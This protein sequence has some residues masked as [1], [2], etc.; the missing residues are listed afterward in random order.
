MTLITPSAYYNFVHNKPSPAKKFYTIGQRLMGTRPKY[1]CIYG[2]SDKVNIIEN[3]YPFLESMCIYFALVMHNK[4]ELKNFTFSKIPNN[5]DEKD[6]T[7]IL[8]KE[9]DSFV[10]M[11]VGKK[12]ILVSFSY[13]DL[14]DGFYF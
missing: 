11:S 2:L 12:T 10:L 9:K 14:K 1:D 7:D 4:M 13:E 6:I 8:M 3:K 5:Y